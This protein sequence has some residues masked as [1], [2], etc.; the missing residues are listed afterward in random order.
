[1]ADHKFD[2]FVETI[3][4][5]CTT[6][7]YTTY[8]CSAGGN[9]GKT[10]NRDETA[11]ID[12]K[13]DVFVETIAPTCITKGYTTYSC[14][15]GGNCGKTENRDETTEVAHKYDVEI[16]VV[17]PICSAEGYTVYGCSA[18]ACGNTENGDYTARTAHTF[19]NIA[20]LEEFGGICCTECGASYLNES[21]EV[22]VET[23]N[24]CIGLCEEGNCTCGI[25]VECTGYI[26]PDAPYA[27]TAG[28][29]FAKDNMEIGTGLIELVSAEEATYTIVIGDATIEVSGT[30][31]VV[32]LYKYASVTSVTIT[33]TADATVVFY[34][35]I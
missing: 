35:Q 33:S 23:D 12:H 30:K 24:I 11:V 4:P 3:A 17:A 7:G 16:E 5:T 31:V 18:G 15:A 27:I 6:T 32:D 9:C 19:E 1:M 13:F 10:E 14:S 28:E 34:V 25:V 2:V 8:S 21:T 22:T 29:A 20:N 26:K